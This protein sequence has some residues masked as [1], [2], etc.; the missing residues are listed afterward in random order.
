MQ[1][2]LIAAILLLGTV[3]TKAQKEGVIEKVPDDIKVITPDSKKQK[4][5]TIRIKGDKAKE[6][7]VTIEIDGDKIK[8]NGKDVADVKDID[9]TIGNTSTMLHMLNPKIMELRKKNALKQEH[10]KDL[11]SKLRDRKNLH[12]FYK[13]TAVL[14]IGMKKVD[15]GVEITGITE[16]SGAQ[17]AGLKD[18]DIITKINGKP[19]VNEMDITKMVNDEKPGTTIEITYKRNGKEQK[20]TATLGKREMNH[21]AFEMPM[22]SPFGDQDHL[23][24]GSPLAQI[25]PMENFNFNGD[26][27]EEN[28]NFDFKGDM[29]EMQFFGEGA[30]NNTPTPKL[31]L[32]LKETETG[33]GLEITDIEENSAAAK[34]GFQKGDIVTH[35]AGESINNVQDIKKAVQNNKAKPFEIKFLR[36]G[37]EQKADIKFPKKLKEVAL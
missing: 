22:I 21:G 25:S 12:L 16:E 14:G 34:A 6:E 1:K 11:M 36:N 35:V 10:L 24:E 37:K 20:T 26:L 27:S 5:V 17:K 18:G 13:N 28:F 23:L 33:K 29:P 4:I 7:K 19:I 9:V 31:G 3:V 30:Y 8:V 2:Y 15:G 32:S